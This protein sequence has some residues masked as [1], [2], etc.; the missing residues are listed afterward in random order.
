MLMDRRVAAGLVFDIF[1]QT[2]YAEGYAPREIARQATAITDL[3]GT[4]SNYPFF[5]IAQGILL[6]TETGKIADGVVLSSKFAFERRGAVAAART[7][8]GDIPLA[9]IVSDGNAKERAFMEDLNAKLLKANRPG[10]FIANTPREAV[11]YLRA[12]NA[13]RLKALFD[14]SEKNAPLA[15]ELRNQMSD[16]M[17]VNDAEFQGFLGY[18]GAEIAKLVIEVQ[19]QFAITRSA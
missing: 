18:A 15:V 13:T 3:P 9:V 19:A 14:E 1:G 5:G 4:F 7:V 17:F 2:A 16:M 12:G 6:S 11:R 10:I 8:L